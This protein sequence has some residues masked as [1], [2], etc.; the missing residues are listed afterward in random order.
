MLSPDLADLDRIYYQQKHHLTLLPTVVFRS[1]L[2]MVT[3]LWHIRAT[4]LTHYCAS[5]LCY[6]GN[7]GIFYFS[8]RERRSRDARTGR[9]SW[10]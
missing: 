9:E 10:Y 5:Q 4:Y 2:L 3:F 1:K 7:Q 8:E 6:R